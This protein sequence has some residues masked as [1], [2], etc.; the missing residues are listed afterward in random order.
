MRIIVIAERSIAVSALGPVGTLPVTQAD[1]T[2]ALPSPFECF[3]V[4]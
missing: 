2:L 1:G 3:A 4:S